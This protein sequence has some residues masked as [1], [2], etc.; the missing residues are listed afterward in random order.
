M[1]FYLRK[2]NDFANQTSNFIKSMGFVVKI[3][4][5]RSF[6]DQDCD[7]NESKIKYKKHEKSIEKAIV[8]H[9]ERRLQIKWMEAK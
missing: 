6:A 3:I 4:G 2:Q 7:E 9:E 5:L 8:A 1:T